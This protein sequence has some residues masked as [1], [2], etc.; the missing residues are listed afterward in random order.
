MASADGLFYIFEVNT[1]EGGVCRLLTQTSLHS[2]K[3]SLL[4]NNLIGHQPSS[5]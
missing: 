5:Q 4:T 3:T 1:Q 2:S